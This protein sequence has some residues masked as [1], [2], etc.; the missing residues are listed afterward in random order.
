MEVLKAQTIAIPSKSTIC[1]LGDFLIN[2][3]EPAS[4]QSYNT[5]INGVKVP[6]YLSPGISTD[7]P[8]T[9]TAVILPS[10]LFTEGINT[11]SITGNQSSRIT[12]KLSDGLVTIDGILDESY[13]NLNNMLYQQLADANN[14]PIPNGGNSAVNFGI[15]WDNT[16]LYIGV[17]VVD[18]T[19]FGKPNFNTDGIDLIEIYID[20]YNI[21]DCYNGCPTGYNLQNLVARQ[22]KIPFNA[23]DENQLDYYD[24]SIQGRSVTGIKMSVKTFTNGEAFKLQ[25]IGSNATRLATLHKGTGFQFEMMIPWES[26]FGIV[27]IPSENF[28]FGFDL[29]Y[30]DNQGRQRRNNGGFGRNEQLF[31]ESSN[32]NANNR[33][34]NT[35]DLGS[36][37]LGGSEVLAQESFISTFTILGITLPKPLTSVA[38]LGDCTNSLTLTGTVAS[39]PGS[40]SYWQ[41]DANLKSTT[42]PVTQNQILGFPFPKSVFINTVD[43]QGCWSKSTEFIVK[44][45]PISTITVSPVFVSYPICNKAIVAATVPTVLN[46]K[47]YWQTTNTAI[48]NA[49]PAIENYTISGENTQ[50]IY[51]RVQNTVTGCW[52]DSLK[53]SVTPISAPDV[54]EPIFAQS[55]VGTCTGL[56]ANVLYSN[57][58]PGTNTWYWQSDVLATSTTS[59]SNLYVLTSSGSIFIKAFRNGCWSRAVG[60]TVTFSDVIIPAPTTKNFVYNQNELSKPLEVTSQNSSLNLVWYIDTP[61]SAKL[62]NAPIPSTKDIGVKNYYVSYTDGICVSSLVGLTVETKEV[63]IA[64]P[65]FYGITPNGDAKNEKFVIDNIT[66]FAGN[67]V[68]I[69]DKWGNVV[70]EKQDYQNDFDG[71]K[72][73]K[74]LPFGNYIYLVDLNDGKKP[75]SGSLILS[76]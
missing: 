18:T 5:Y 49:L 13:W 33:W 48:S 62:V 17:K 59:S 28:S 20:P 31:W 34:N 53:V 74:D 70:F 56:T 60:T 72:D 39:V 6:Q 58:V 55:I 71:K 19:M 15:L 50:E 76:R 11:I 68:S 41:T 43:D 66:L 21:D 9:K 14:N 47:N 22:L 3:N 1:G 73:G 4:Y 63:I 29:A 54:P 52:S 25:S 16:A 45:L 27:T 10:N 67:K 8:P 64:L 12:K 44:P 42:N 51:L 40:L 57:S 35:L 61:N 46:Q 23:I 7:A 69:I 36:L 32:S 75:L 37:T 24:N 38:S 26:F 30:N 2:I 65:K